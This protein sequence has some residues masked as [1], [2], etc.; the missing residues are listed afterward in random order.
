M[1]Q[2]FH[3]LLTSIKKPQDFSL[4]FVFVKSTESGFGWNND[5]IQAH[6]LLLDV[7]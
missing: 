3:L 2:A 7:S 5:T 1:T 4:V 6:Q